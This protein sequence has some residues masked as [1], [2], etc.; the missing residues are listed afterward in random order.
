[1][2]LPWE[3]L[4][5]H[6]LL[7]SSYSKEEQKQF[8]EILKQGTAWPGH[9]WLA[10]SGSVSPK[11]VGLSKQAILISAAAVN[12]HL[13]SGKEDCWINPLPSFH[14]GGLGIIARAHLS[15]AKIHDYKQIHPGKWK[16]EEFYRFLQEKKGTLTSLVP[17]QLH[18]LIE[19]RFRAPAELRAVIIGGGALLPSLYEKSAALGWP[20]L[21]SYGMT[22]CAS[23]IATA[24]L[25]GWKAGCLPSLQLLPHVSC[26]IQNGRFSFAGPS[27]LSTYAYLE[28]GGVRY[29]DPKVDGWLLS[30]D[31]GSIENGHLTIHGRADAICKVG[32]ESVDLALL[33][34]RLQTLKLQM[35]LKLEATLIAME[36]PRLGHTIQLASDCPNKELL[37]PLIDAFQKS[38]LPFERIRKTHLVK[39]L[40]RS[41][42]GKLLR[43]ELLALIKTG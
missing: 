17:A 21:P 8:N 22:E 6:L 31:C 35:G 7:N 18:D 23:Q 12:K 26:K 37:E 30:E 28:K 19:L 43:Q 1:M 32:G 33:E 13:K 10:T 36:D 41:A 15:G 9:L 20:V 24:S 3:S 4:E 39:E 27:L 25:E 5:S 11:W 14:V 2:N 16:A 42:L 38:V 40:P 34:N 29:A